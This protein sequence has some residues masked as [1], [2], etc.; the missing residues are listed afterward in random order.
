MV[1]DK[2]VNVQIKGIRDGLLVTLGE[3]EWPDLQ[4]SLLSRIQ[5]R[6]AFFQGAR[7]ALDVGNH[8]SARR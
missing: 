6:A 4:S 3:G 1:M 7:V 8:I 5:E 2:R